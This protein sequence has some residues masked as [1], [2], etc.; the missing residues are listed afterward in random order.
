M[1][2]DTQVV[3]MRLAIYA[4]SEVNGGEWRRLS[5]AGEAVAEALGLARES[6]FSIK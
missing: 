1:F 4:H 3:P 2:G 5:N 6:R